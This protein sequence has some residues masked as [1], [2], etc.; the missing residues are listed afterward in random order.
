VELIAAQ[1]AAGMDFEKAVRLRKERGLDGLKVI[2]SPDFDD[3]TFSR[4]ALGL[5]E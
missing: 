5:D 1:R 3:P 4:Q 2:I